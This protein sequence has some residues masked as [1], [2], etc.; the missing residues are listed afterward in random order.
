MIFRTIQAAFI[1]LAGLSTAA[2][3]QSTAVHVPPA[4]PI[5][6]ET[7]AVPKQLEIRDSDYPLQS[8]LANEEGRV[9]LNLLVGA[10][11]RVAFAQVLMGSGSQRLDQAA[12]Q[13]A[14]TRWEFQPHMKGGQPAVGSARVEVTWK[15]PLTPAYEH[16]MDPSLLPQDGDISFEPAIATTSHALRAE[17]Y[18]VYAIRTGLQ[19]RVSLR[20]V[21][22]ESGSVTDV[23]IVQTSG[24]S[25]L[26]EAAAKVVKERWLYKPA[27]LNGKPVP[28]LTHATF[29][30]QLRRSGQRPRPARNCYPAPRL[31]TSLT[32]SPEGGEESVEVSQ[33]IHLTADGTVDDLIVRTQRGWM[34]FA[35]STVEEYSRAA[36]FPP[37]AR[38]RRPPSCWFDGTVTVTADQK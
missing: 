25:I 21:I 17:D 29:V 23:G 15:A 11:G 12:A 6:G 32:M 36:K 30:F 27:T 1:V 3:A 5:D 34:H 19:G 24:A 4:M 38:E 22:S 8:L 26:D 14:R 16:Q 10:D 9:A 28:T 31:G 33:W 7:F 20:F 35:P 18:P 2:V 13:L 37:A